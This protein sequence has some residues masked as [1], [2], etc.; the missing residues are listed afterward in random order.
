LEEILNVYLGEMGRH[1]LREPLG[2]VLR[3][4]TSNARH[5]NLKRA[6][7]R[8]KGLDIGNPE[9]YRRG[10]S[11]MGQDWGGREESYLW[12]LEKEGLH[13]KVSYLFR[14]RVL[15]LAVQNNNPLVAEEEFRVRVVV[16]QAW[17]LPRP[18]EA[19][20]TGLGGVVMFLRKIGLSE[21]AIT[22]EGLPGETVTTLRVPL[23]RIQIVKTPD[24]ADELVRAIEDLPPFPANL[25]RILGLLE[26]PDVVFADLAREL[27]L[28]PGMTADLI[29]YINS[30]AHRGPRRIESLDDA[31][32]QVGIQRLKDLLYPYGA[33]QVLE[34]FLAQQETLWENATT[35]SRY[36]LAIARER[37][38]D[39]HDKG[40]VQIAGLLYN[41]GQ[42][43]AS[44]LNPEFSRRILEFCRRKGISVV[45]FDDLSR[46]INP[47]E[48]GARIASKWNFPQDLVS[49]LAYQSD[50]TSAP[51][52]D[53]VAAAAVH[54]ASCLRS[55]ELGLLSYRQIPPESVRLLGLDVLDMESLHGRIR[56]EG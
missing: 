14:D 5:A 55:V 28:D 44:Y 29:K 11:A 40:L 10:M 26:D 34:K 53:Q 1:S 15:T 18:E 54:L 47:V 46:T 16:A 33:H 19:L 17:A 8:D 4:L 3:E 23:D 36:A 31:V 52:P 27:A 56:N 22:I 37:R 7:F 50:P 9:D 20:E 30:A 43:V 2:Y 48:L 45:A 35:V 12:L 39:L 6:Y 21:G 49:V 41:L 42:I 24:L 32:R 25:S 51:G 38:F 13:L